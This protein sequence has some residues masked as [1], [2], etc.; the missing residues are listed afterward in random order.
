MNERMNEWYSTAQ[1]MALF[2]LNG[3]GALA[4]ISFFDS[5]GPSLLPSSS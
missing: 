4:P 1:L 5:T 2:I 3:F